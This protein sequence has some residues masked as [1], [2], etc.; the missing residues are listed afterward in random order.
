MSCHRTRKRL[1]LPV[2]KLTRVPV[3]GRGGWVGGK[4]MLMKRGKSV[5]LTEEAE[6]P[7]TQQKE[8]TEGRQQASRLPVL[9][10]A[11][12]PTSLGTSTMFSTTLSKNC[13][14]EGPLR[15]NIR[16]SRGKLLL[17]WAVSCLVWFYPYR[18][19]Q[20]HATA[21]PISAKDFPSLILLYL[22]AGKIPS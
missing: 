11:I 17:S 16:D 4:K 2:V 3:L 19:H 21:F 18:F 20:V 8:Q 5:E 15:S 10:S 14:S 7:R 6:N 9:S 12:S 22:E 13:S 1:L